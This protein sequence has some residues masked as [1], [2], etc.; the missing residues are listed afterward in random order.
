M[1]DDDIG[2]CWQID[3]KGKGHAKPRGR[4]KGNAKGLGKGDGLAHVCTKYVTF[5]SATVPCRAGSLALVI[6]RVVPIAQYR[7]GGNDRNKGIANRVA[8]VTFWCVVR[9]RILVA[10]QSKHLIRL[11][12]VAV[13]TKH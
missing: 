2:W 1:W 13:S 9:C 11:Q 5:S 3:G 8:Q 12:P 6:V 10:L 7:H 4:G